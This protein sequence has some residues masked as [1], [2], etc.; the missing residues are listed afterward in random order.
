MNQMKKYNYIKYLHLFA[1]YIWIEREI[2][3]DDKNVNKC[4]KLIFY[5]NII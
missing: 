4:E 2:L 1:K 3:L 5:G